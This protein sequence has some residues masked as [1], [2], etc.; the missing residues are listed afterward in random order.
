MDFME[1]REPHQLA[2]TLALHA[3][4]EERCQCGRNRLPAD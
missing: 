4:T 1:L 2:K 3:H